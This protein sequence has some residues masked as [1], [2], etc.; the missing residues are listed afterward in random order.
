[1]SP[2]VSL[3]D[4]YARDHGRVF[5]SGTQ[6]LVRLPLM[7]LERDRAAGRDTACYITG[8]RGSPLAGLDRQLAAAKPF[9]DGKPIVFQ[10]GL[11][12]DLAATAVWGTQQ[13]G[14]NG[15]AKHAGVFAMW[16]AKGPGVDRSGDALRHGNLAGSAPLGGV[17]LLAGDDHTCES[18]TTCHQSEFAFADAMIPVLNPADV[19]EIIDFGL[20]GWALSR[21]SG[22]WVALKCVKDNVEATASVAIDPGRVAIRIPSDHVV[23]ANGLGIRWPDTPQD[24]EARLH[25]HKLAAAQAFCR[26]NA[27]DR[28]VIDGPAARLGIATTGK[29]YSDVRQALD[30][31]GLDDEAAAAAGIRLFKIGMSWPLE[32][33]AASAFADGLDLVMVVEEKRSLI[34]IQ[35]KEL[36]YGRPGA[37]RIVGKRDEQGAGLLPSAGAL[38]P[39]QIA[40]AIARH[41]GRSVTASSTS[42]PGRDLLQR[43]V[44]FCAGCPHS[45]STRLPEHSRGYCGIGC[46]GMVQFMD[47]GTAGLT[48]M[49]GEGLSWVGEAPFAKDAHV[50]QTLGDGT[51]YHSGLLAIRAAVASHTNIT[52]KILF[53]DAVA[54]T[55]G[56][57]HD[58]PLTVQAITRQVHAEGVARVVVVS[59]EP[60]KYG[61]GKRGF[62]PGV[63][64]HGRDELDAVQ[65][66]LRETPGTTVLVFDQVCATEKRRRRKRG[67]AP[68]AARRLFI[69][70]PVCEGCGDCG[71]Q[72]NCTAIVPLETPLGRKRAI[73]QFACNTD[74]SCTAGFCPSFVTITGGRPRAGKAGVL[75]A[76]F[77]ALP[78]PRRPALDRPYSIVIAGI[79]GTGVVTVGALVGM[80]AHI[81][82][83]GC[84]VLDMTGL[85]Q[86]GGSVWTHIKIGATQEAIRA[87]RAAPGGADL[88]LGCD[89]VVAASGQ[90]RALLRRGAS[91]VVLNTAAVMPGEFTRKPDLAFPGAQMR[92]AIE[93]SAG[94]PQVHAVDAGAIARALF[95]DS[96][97]VNMFMLGYAWQ[98]GLVPVGARALEE[99]I[100]LNGTS[101]AQT[102]AAFLWGRRA[103]HD[104]AAV[105]RL[106]TV[107]PPSA[108]TLDDTIRSHVEFLTE[109][110]DAAYARRY[111]ALV[112]AARA[113]EHALMPG[114]TRLTEAVARNAF[115]LLACKDEYEVARLYSRPEFAR[116]LAE[117]FAGDY[118]IAFNLAPPL[119]A[120]RDRATGLPRKI[121]FGPWLLTA[122]RLLARARRLR[123]T[124][125]D[126]FGWTS[127]RRAE[128][129]LVGWY[130]ELVGEIIADLSPGNHDLAVELASLPAG[131][132]GFGHVKQKAIAR[133]KARER[134]LRAAWREPLQSASV[135]A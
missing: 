13:A 2:P 127:E 125:F 60:H 109:Y 122:F 130:E 120:P 57:S 40:A 48:Q 31:L 131:I 1:M 98:K 45:S 11:N 49:G 132:R 41:L 33:R 91:S 97:T 65:R 52:F 63:T 83:K 37:P 69:Y 81:E 117:Q 113:R 76:P 15:P 73:D 23:P 47:R 129:A 89:L 62:A 107:A 66:R 38:D 111:A 9:F 90:T 32:P 3:D 39:A 67:L 27:L 64:I 119:L 114:S 10:P 115:K 128:R 124:P 85:A 92:A 126:P 86:K 110:Q 6:A 29:S 68:A 93:A 42:A 71:V 18:S 105:M 35:L 51:Y 61:A 53:N 7:Q 22:C 19:Q 133:A 44:H 4:K 70:D 104:P 102:S 58:G 36:L 8:Y 25:E 59:D 94:V 84:G 77:A 121:S 56:Q 28:V 75:E 30:L 99:A 24:Q 108:L 116:K 106:I 74:F 16:Y 96:I 54:M 82:G 88:V 55:G 43:G 118:R 78:E 17:L 12:E 101:V 112:G 20:H 80:A 103:A 95:G 72:S 46:S 87:I 134:E 135:A 34:E 79:G 26:A 14:L 100:R 21:Y 5:I 123:G 50:F